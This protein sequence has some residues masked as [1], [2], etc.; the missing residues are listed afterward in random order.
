MEVEYEV[1]LGHTQGQTYKYAVLKIQISP[2]L[3]T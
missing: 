2:E 3:L 1:M